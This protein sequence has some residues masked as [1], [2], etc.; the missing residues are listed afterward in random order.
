LRV[1]GLAGKYRVRL[2]QS[3]SEPESSVS[4]RMRNSGSY[5]LKVG[6]SATSQGG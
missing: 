4:L 3:A 2:K 6:D 5:T 1:L